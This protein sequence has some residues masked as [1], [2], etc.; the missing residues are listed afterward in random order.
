MDKLDAAI[1]EISKEFPTIRRVTTTYAQID[2]DELFDWWNYIFI[3]VLYAKEKDQVILTDMADYAPLCK[4][5]EEDLPEVEKICQ[6]HNITFH[7]WHIECVYQ[8]NQ[9]IKN[10]LACLR[11]LSTKYADN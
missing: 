3:G 2:F 1:A 8:S 7:N 9:D 5:E 6:K 10:Y 4:W 11:E